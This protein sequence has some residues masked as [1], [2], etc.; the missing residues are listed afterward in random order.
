MISSHLVSTSQDVVE[1]EAMIV[2]CLPV[3]AK[4]A[5]HV[6]RQQPSYPDTVSELLKPYDARLMRCHPAST[7]INHVSNDDEE[8]C[9][10][11]EIAIRCS[12]GVCTH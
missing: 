5:S 2:T 4:P 6:P 1:G 9:Q 11:H 7:R 10:P 3:Q 12:P 8:C